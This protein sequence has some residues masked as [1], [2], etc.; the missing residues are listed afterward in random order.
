M[1]FFPAL[2]ELEVR[3]TRNPSYLHSLWLGVWVSVVSLPEVVY[4]AMGP[5][6]VRLLLMWI[7]LIGSTVIEVLNG[8]LLMA[9]CVVA[10]LFKG[11]FGYLGSKD[12]SVVS[13]T[14]APNS[15]D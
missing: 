11:M 13:D 15:R 7:R 4:R 9:T 2:S 12:E 14:S 1:K 5:R 10:P 3:D 6:L 8:L